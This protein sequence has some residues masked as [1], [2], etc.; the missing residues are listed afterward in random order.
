[1]TH[2]ILTS[3]R[4]DVEM[5]QIVDFEMCFVCVGLEYLVSG[6]CFRIDPIMRSG[7]SRY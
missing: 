6:S 5:T 7:Y 1:M 2:I 3:S 4:S